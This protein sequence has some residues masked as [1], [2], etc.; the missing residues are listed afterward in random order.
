MVA[1]HE[2]DPGESASFSTYNYTTDSFVEAMRMYS[3][4]Q[5]MKLFS[6]DVPIPLPVPLK[7]REIKF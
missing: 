7:I 6:T 5:T 1:S 4:T 2:V 3:T